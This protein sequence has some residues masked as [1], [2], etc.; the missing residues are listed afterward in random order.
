MASLFI[1]AAVLKLSN[2]QGFAEAIQGFQIVPGHLVKLLAYALPWTELLAGVLLLIGMWS[3]ACALLIT[4]LL[5]GFIVGI[6][7]VLWR[8]L[9]TTCACF[10]SLEFPCGHEVGYCQIIRNTVFVGLALPVII[11]GPGRFAVGRY[12][13]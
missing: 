4:L 2:P 13:Q 6:A 11:Y 9:S 3:R 5:L 7:S 10:G 8:G 1:L 12:D